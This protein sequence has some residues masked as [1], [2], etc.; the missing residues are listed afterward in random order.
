MLMTERDHETP[1]FHKDVCPSTFLP[2]ATRLSMSAA[3]P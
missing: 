3:V 1:P 2:I